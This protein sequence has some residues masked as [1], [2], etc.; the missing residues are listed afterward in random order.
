MLDIKEFEKGLAAFGFFPKVVDLQCLM[1]FYDKNGDKQ[2]DFEEFIT[3]I[4][5]PLNER[6]NKLI[7]KI[8]K[9]LDPENQGVITLQTLHNNFSAAKNKQ[10]IE[11]LKSQDEIFEEFLEAISIA[12]KADPDCPCT[13]QQFFDYYTDLGVSIPSDNYFSEIA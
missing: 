1:K 6:R 11:K 9:K 7:M 2:I 4:R 3:A 8:W 13:K 5:D 10:V 12:D